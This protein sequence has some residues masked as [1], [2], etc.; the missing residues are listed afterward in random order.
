MLVEVVSDRARGRCGIFNIGKGTSRCEEAKNA[1]DVGKNI[2][3]KVSLAP[4][5]RRGV[6]NLFV[7][8]GQF[9]RE[10]N[11]GTPIRISHGE[12]GTSSRILSRLEYNQS[13]TDKLTRRQEEER[14]SLDEHRSWVMPT[15]EEQK[16]RVHEKTTG[17]AR[18]RVIVVVDRSLGLE[19]WGF[20]DSGMG[21][22]DPCHLTFFCPGVL[23]DTML[24]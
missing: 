9:E 11:P 24:C 14:V 10:T 18:K 6:E 17:G 16:C 20:P 23:Q 2:A 5:P 1:R 22:L 8:R 4:S 13:H 15:N 3:K 21:K 12:Q 19:S 7:V